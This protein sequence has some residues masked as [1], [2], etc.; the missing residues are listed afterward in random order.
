VEIAD[1]LDRNMNTVLFPSS[2]M[3][4]GNSR[5]DIYCVYIEISK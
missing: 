4:R 5:Y 1:T 3:T 2:D